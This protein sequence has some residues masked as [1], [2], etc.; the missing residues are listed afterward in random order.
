MDN[1][2]EQ[3]KQQI[4]DELNLEETTPADIDPAAPLFGDKGLG[5]DSIDALELVMLLEKY[6]GIKIPEPKQAKEVFTSVN[7]IAEYIKANKK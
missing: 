6:Y 5:L 3:L 7:S 2:I 1:L 4:I